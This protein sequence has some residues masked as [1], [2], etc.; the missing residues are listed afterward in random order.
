M[1]S[2]LLFLNVFLLVRIMIIKKDV[3]WDLCLRV[4]VILRKVAKSLDFSRFT[5]RL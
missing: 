5:A 4:V 3:Q 2:D 1:V